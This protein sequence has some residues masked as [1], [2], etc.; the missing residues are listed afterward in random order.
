MI[1]NVTFPNPILLIKLENIL[2][3]QYTLVHQ[4]NKLLRISVVITEKY[5]GLSTTTTLIP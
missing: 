5:L 2:T 4:Q 1:I 3:N